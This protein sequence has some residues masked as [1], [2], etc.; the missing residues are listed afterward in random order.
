MTPAGSHSPQRT[1]R[2][3]VNGTTASGSDSPDFVK[4]VEN[5]RTYPA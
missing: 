4:R 5:R 2:R 3:T 1:L